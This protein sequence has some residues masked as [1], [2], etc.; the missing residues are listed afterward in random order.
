MPDLRAFPP[1]KVPERPKPVHNYQ[2]GNFPNLSNLLI[3]EQSI[4]QD[5]AL[6]DRL[7]EFIL[8]KPGL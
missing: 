5:K 2:S 8:A 7:P 4:L 1:G 3:P 6:H